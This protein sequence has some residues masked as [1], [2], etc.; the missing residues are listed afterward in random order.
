MTDIHLT[1]N[2]EAVTVK[3][4]TALSSLLPNHPKGAAVVLLK[5]KTASS[6]KTSRMRLKTTAGDV[7]IELFKGETLPEASFP[8]TPGDS[9]KIHFEDK[10]TAAFGPFPTSFVP[11]MQEFRFPRGA[12]FVGSGG[13]DSKRSYLM[14]SRNEHKADHGTAAGGA[15]IG[16]VIYGLG[17][18]DRWRHGDKILEAEQVFSRV[19]ADNAEIITDLSRKAEDG[20]QVFSK[21]TITAEG[22]AENPAEIRTETAESVDHLL[23]VL[24]DG[25][26]AVDRSASTCI[27]DHTEGKLA[28]PQELQ[29]ARREGA[30]TARTAGKSSGAIYIYT[31]DIQSHPAH[32]IVGTVTAGIE[33]ARFAAPGCTLQTEVNPPLLDL[34]GMLLKDAVAAAKSRGLKVM[35]DNRDVESRVVIDQ[36]PAYTL[37]VLK[38]GKVSLYTKSLDEVIDITLDYENAP[39]SVDLFRRVTNLKRYPV[40]TMPFIFNDGEMY[41]FKPQFAKGINIIPENCPKKTPAKDALALSN[42]SRPAQGMVGVRLEEN[43]EFGPTGEPFS[44]TNIIGRVIDTEKLS[45]M[46]EDTVIYIREVKQ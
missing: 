4:G 27:R 31:S 17:I 41:L 20:M 45:K 36:K 26:Y 39:L 24:K 5:P 8:K 46:K 7:I 44:G 3:K 38:E 21:I 9:L 1:V 19:D 10:N 13:Y 16:K 25:R 2:G 18:M 29:S 33:L 11:A 42:D 15:V 34:R 28:V 23:F 6:E 43:A 30:V 35:A 12:V 14:F 22:Y 32:T 37:E 40:G